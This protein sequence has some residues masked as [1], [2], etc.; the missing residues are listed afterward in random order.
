MRLK[1]GTSEIFF[2]M[3]AKNYLYKKCMITIFIFYLPDKWVWDA[4]CWR[5]CWCICICMCCCWCKRSRI[6]WISLRSDVSRTSIR[7]DIS[8]S[9][10]LIKLLRDKIL[11]YWKFITIECFTLYQLRE[12]N[13]RLE[14][15]ERLHP[16]D[17]YSNSWGFHLYC[18]L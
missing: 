10:F 9:W 5:V 3:W 15:V 8:A 1:L 17:L 6:E 11:K 14:R 4:A 2:F 18:A 13:K 7:D 16:Q 12:G